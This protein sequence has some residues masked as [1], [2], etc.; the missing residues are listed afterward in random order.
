[1]QH[2]LLPK[3]LTQVLRVDEGG[4]ALAVRASPPAG[5]PAALPVMELAAG[6][7][8]LVQDG[9]HARGEHARTVGVQVEAFVADDGLVD[10]APVALA[11]VVGLRKRKK[12]KKVMRRRPSL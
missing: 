9:V 5:S 8:H 10:T 6:D 12:K 1:M 2:L 11:L 4:P 7:V 3:E